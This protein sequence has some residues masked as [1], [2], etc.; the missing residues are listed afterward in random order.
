[1]VVW[2]GLGLAVG[3]GGAQE[4]AVPVPAADAIPFARAVLKTKGGDKL[5][6]VVTIEEGVIVIQPEGGDAQ[7]TSL[8]EVAG[9]EVELVSPG[10]SKEANETSPTGALPAPWRSRD[11]GRTV[12]P[13]KAR[14]RDGRFVVAASPQ[15]ADERF[16]AFHLVYAPAEGDCE[17]QARVVSLNNEDE[18]SYAGIVIC[19]GTTP[20]NRKA[21]LGVHPH[22]EK[23][24]H[25]RRWGYQGGSSTGTEL[26]SL[27]LPYWVKLVREDYDVTAYYSP[28]GRRWKLLKVSSGKM[29]D[30]KVYMGLAVRMQKGDRLSEAVIDNVSI[31]GEGS[32]EAKPMLPQVVLRSGSRVATD[33]AK[34]NSTAFHFKGRWQGTAITAP[35]VARVE[36]FHPLPDEVAEVVQGERAGLLLRSGDFAEGAFDSLEEGK[37]RMG[38]LLFGTKEHSILDEADCLVLRKVAK[39]PA[40]YRVE[41]HGGSVLL[42]QEAKLVGDRLVV[43]VAGLGE[44]RVGVSELKVLARDEERQ[45]P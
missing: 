35:Q 26:P 27:K 11:L 21:V 32:E 31:N 44:V 4:E 33:L 45:E 38:S 7:R 39:A 19:D 28:D 3:V 2:A 41:T 42:A 14:W 36:F 24:I 23:G 12:V 29:R 43:Q 30:Q 1:M 18:G 22:G 5:Q 13:G 37:I 15:V 8:A 10:D 9:L 6:G 34:A 25:F 17:I 16:S 20:E 40:R